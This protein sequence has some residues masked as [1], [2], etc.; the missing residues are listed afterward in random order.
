MLIASLRGKKQAH[1]ESSS[2][3]KEGGETRCPLWFETAIGLRL[4]DLGEVH[5]LYGHAGILLSAVRPGDIGS[6]GRTAVSRV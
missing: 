1:R 3:I 5:A 4:G 6:P 2:K